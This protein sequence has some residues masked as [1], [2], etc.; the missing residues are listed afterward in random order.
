MPGFTPEYEKALI[1][2]IRK[3]N[4]AAFATIFSLYYK[5]LVV[6]SFSY[7]RNM[8]VAEELVQD[9][10]VRLWEKHT[11]L[12]ITS[13]L[14]AF[15]LKSVQNACFNWIKHHAMVQKHSMILAKS[16]LLAD[17]ETEHYILHSD[18]Q[19]RLN[20]ALEKLPEEQREVFR[21]NRLDQ[22]RY[23]DIAQ[24]YGVSIRTIE[25]RMAKALQ[26]L[27]K[28][29]IDLLPVIFLLILFFV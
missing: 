7:T 23:E 11:S 6:F 20:E 21:L 10:F 15:L 5:D 22:L 13:S 14:K 9:L 12:D 26:F 27:R 24:K 4:Q 3:G 16:M 18:L 25:V 17:E 2:K 19:N 8:E 28:E 29:L 1:Q